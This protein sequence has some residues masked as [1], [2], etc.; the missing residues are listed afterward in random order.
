MQFSHNRKLYRSHRDRVIAG[1]CSGIA[2]YFGVDP[3]FVRLLFLLL[4]FG[5]SWGPAVIFYFVLVLLIP[6]DTAEER[7]TS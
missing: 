7:Q 3:V 1:V 6:E 2:G 5:L 4:A